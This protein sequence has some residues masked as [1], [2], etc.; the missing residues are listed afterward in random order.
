M[1]KAS[2]KTGQIK[3]YIDSRFNGADVIQNESYPFTT[4]TSSNTKELTLETKQVTKKN[5]NNLD[6]NKVEAEVE[7]FPPADSRLNQSVNQEAI[8]LDFSEK[9]RNRIISQHAQKRNNISPL[10][11]AGNGHKQYP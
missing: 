3:S 1:G 11:T 8:S 5:T 4:N 9:M 6:Q 7:F 2:S 10:K